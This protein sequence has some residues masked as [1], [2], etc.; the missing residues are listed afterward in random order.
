[1][2]FTKHRGS[3]IENHKLFGGKDPESRFGKILKTMID[4]IPDEISLGAPRADLGSHS[5]RKGSITYVLGFPIIA[6][7][8]VYLRAGWSLGN[9]QDRYIFGGAGGDQLV[10]RAVSGLPINNIDFSVLPPHFSKDDLESLDKFGWSIILSDYENFPTCFKYVVPF[11]MAS[12]IY[13]SKFLKEC[14][15]DGHP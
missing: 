7:V 6:A 10:G 13:H 4:N 12:L 11:L 3:D 1:M 5:Q 15:G 9:V 14:F 2:V 8:Q